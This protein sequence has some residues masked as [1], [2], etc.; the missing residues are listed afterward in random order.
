MDIKT[1]DK[2][3]SQTIL[4]I[5]NKLIIIEITIDLQITEAT[6]EA[7]IA[8]II[9]GVHI[10]VI[11]EAITEDTI[12]TETI[13]TEDIIEITTKTPIIIKIKK[14]KKITDALAVK[15]YIRYPPSVLTMAQ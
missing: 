5:T 1:I 15:P 4:I 9:T 8:V 3:I 7:T 14:K 11:I 10:E 12:T 2:T 6:I 13:T